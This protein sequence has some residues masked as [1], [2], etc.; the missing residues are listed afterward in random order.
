MKFS[1]SA[2]RSLRTCNESGDTGPLWH[3][4]HCSALASRAALT[5]ESLTHLPQHGVATASLSKAPVRAH[6][7]CVGAELRSMPVSAA[8]L[9]SFS[10]EAEVASN[11]SNEPS[12]CSMTVLVV[13]SMPSRVDTLR[14][15]VRGTFISRI[16][17]SN[18]V[19]P[20]VGQCFA[21]CPGF[22]QRLQRKPPAPLPLRAGGGRTP[23]TGAGAASLLQAETG[24]VRRSTVSSSSSSFRMLSSSSS[25]S[26][27]TSATSIFTGSAMGVMAAV[28]GVGKGSSSASCTFMG[29]TISELCGPPA[30]PE[31]VFLLFSRAMREF[32]EGMRFTTTVEFL[33]TVSSSSL[34]SLEVFSSTILR[35]KSKLPEIFFLSRISFLRSSSLIQLPEKV[36]CSCVFPWCMR[37][38]TTERAML[39]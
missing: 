38:F 21:M 36:T 22:R 37:K 33:G 10:R 30:P 17:G 9:L 28:M 26:A 11:T 13:V 20:L 8:S 19:F 6:L 29:I 18:A 1:T 35:S 31:R 24:T 16:S 39:S 4:G 12:A 23:G 25:G 7:R 2:R 15:P 27:S 5:A 32:L 34:Y 14:L 3:R